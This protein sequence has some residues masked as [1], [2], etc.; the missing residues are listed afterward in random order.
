[1]PMN[2]RLLDALHSHEV[3]WMEFLEKAKILD[4]ATGPEKIALQNDL[5]DW[6]EKTY[7]PHTYKYPR[8][9]EPSEIEKRMMNVVFNDSINGSLIQAGRDYEVLDDSRKTVL[10]LANLDV[11][12]IS[13]SEDSNY[14]KIASWRLTHRYMT[15]SDEKLLDWWEHDGGW[16]RFYKA[17]ENGDPFRIWYS[18]EP[19]ELC[20]FF[21]LC[22]L[23][24]DYT[25]GVYAVKIPERI[26]YE[27]K[28]KYFLT[29]SSGNLDPF[30]VG[31]ALENE[32]KLS[33]WELRL[34]AE[35][36]ERLKKENAPLR[37]VIAGRIISVEEDFYDS[38]IL[39]HVPSAPA[40]EEQ[41]FGKVLE[42][43]PFIQQGWITLRIQHMI[44]QGEIAVIKDN[45]NP[46]RRVICR[47]KESL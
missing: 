45:A 17:M 28:R 20:G 42:N 19:K 1:M 21:Y 16:K 12:Y 3:N 9:G 30:N 10:Y 47:K 41:V 7:P 8:A 18:E 2:K 44:D 46:A 39:K 34:Y 33:R 25:G 32:V 5:A 22:L 43:L 38:L 31:K 26:R 29:N 6:I 24:K 4:G 35:E 13:E 23:L 36:W 40:T 15:E 14:R 27:E 37:T 11:G